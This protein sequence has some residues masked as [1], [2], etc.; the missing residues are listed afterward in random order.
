MTKEQKDKVGTEDGR[1]DFQAA[2][3]A[4]DNDQIVDDR[5]HEFKHGRIAERD[6]AEQE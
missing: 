3:I 4:A 1:H 2:T 6:E 5:G